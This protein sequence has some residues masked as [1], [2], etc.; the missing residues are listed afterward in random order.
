[1]VKK[2]HPVVQRGDEDS[3]AS[4]IAVNFNCRKQS[5]THARLTHSA[6]GTVF[7]RQNLTSVDMVDVR[8]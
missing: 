8:F 4:R 2:K 5:V 7:R 3:T 1:M 6:R